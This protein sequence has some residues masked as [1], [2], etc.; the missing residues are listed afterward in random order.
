M[1]QLA[2]ALTRLFERHRI[3]FWYDEKREL[4]AEYD[5]LALPGVEKIELGNNQFGVKH[6]VLRQEPEQR[7]LLYHAGPPPADLDNWLLDVE[8]AHGRFRADQTALWLTELGLGPEFTD[9][10]APHA[11]F[12]QA[13]RRRESLKALLDAG[14]TA[15]GIRLKMLAVCAAPGGDG[16]PLGAEPRLDSILGAL[17]A[18]RL[19]VGAV[20]ARVRLRIGDAR[21]ARFCAHALS[22]LLRGRRW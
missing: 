7:F 16:S 20:P 19:P 8:L 21:A 6:R 13:A 18:E 5:A 22:L 17:R 9:V 3:V 11:E 10:V 15:Q 12:F 2:Q 1:S 4:R 14:D